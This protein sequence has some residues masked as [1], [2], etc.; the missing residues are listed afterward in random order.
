[1]G[2]FI[3]EVIHSSPSDGKSVVGA[4]SPADLIENNQASLFGAAENIGEFA[5]FYKECRLSLC[6]I[7]RGSDS[8]ENPIYDTDSGVLTRD[9]TTRLRHQYNECGLPHVSRFTSHIR[10]GDDQH[11]GVC[12][13]QIGIVAYK[14]T[15]CNHLFDNRVSALFDLQFKTFVDNWLYIAQL[16]ADIGKT[17]KDIQLR[18][19]LRCLLNF[20]DKSLNF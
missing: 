3:A 17:A 1:M 11:T 6:Q 20:S 10:S 19:S 5:H 8:S 16:I 7:I 13:V 12:V 9:K 2:G 4:C 18:N 14:H 15:I